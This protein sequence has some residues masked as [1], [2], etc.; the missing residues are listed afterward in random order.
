MYN[1]LDNLKAQLGLGTAGVAFSGGI[2]SSLLLKM[3]RQNN[4][5]LITS[6]IKI[7]Y[8][9]ISQNRWPLRYL[10]NFRFYDSTTL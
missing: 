1:I 2:V 10:S 3:F 9:E 8:W 4:F 6:E 5:L 7:P